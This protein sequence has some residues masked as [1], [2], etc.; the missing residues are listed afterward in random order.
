MFRSTRQLALLKSSTLT[1]TQRHRT[2]FSQLY[3]QYLSP[4]AKM[5][6]CQLMAL[7]VGLRSELMVGSAEGPARV[8]LLHEVRV[9]AAAVRWPLP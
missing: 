4:C 6:N 8:T 9:S 1:S 7:K 3:H 2:Q 5:I